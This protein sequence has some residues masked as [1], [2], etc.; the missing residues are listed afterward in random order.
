LK[1]QGIKVDS[2]VF[3]T[4]AFSLTVTEPGWLIY[5]DAFD[6]RFSVRIDGADAVDWRANFVY[7]AVHLDPGSHTG[8]WRFGKNDLRTSVFLAFEVVSVIF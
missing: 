1:Y 3:D 5:A 6:P 4:V 2:F 8:E 7:K